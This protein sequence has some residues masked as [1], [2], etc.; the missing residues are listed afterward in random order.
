MLC[1]YLT[2]VTYAA[3]HGMNLK[4]YDAVTPDGWILRLWRVRSPNIFEEQFSAPVIV[5]HGFGSS[6][7]DYMLNL[8]NQSIAFILADNGYDVWLTNYRANE[9]S[10]LKISNGIRRM[11]QRTE[12][13]KA[14]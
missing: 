13:Y 4:Y 1:I 2:Q 12:Y 8:R 6:S 5:S 3:L 11:P 10:N 7:F 9:F 14:A